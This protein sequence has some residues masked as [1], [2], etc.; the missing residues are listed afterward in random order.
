MESDKELIRLGRYAEAL[1]NNYDPYG[2]VIFLMRDGICFGHYKDEKGKDYK[3]LSF[4]DAEKHIGKR[5]KKGK[6]K[7]A[8]NEHWMGWNSN[9]DWL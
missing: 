8:D 7:L 4:D 9:S 6:L 2:W 1:G 5:I 3:F